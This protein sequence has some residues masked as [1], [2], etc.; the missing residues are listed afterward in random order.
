MVASLAR[1]SLK[2]KEQCLPR[3]TATVDNYEGDSVAQKVMLFSDK[4]NSLSV[5]NDNCRVTAMM[6]FFFF[7]FF[8]EG[9]GYC[10]HNV[11]VSVRLSILRLQTFV[12]FLIS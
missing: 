8:F 12:F 4:Q 1:N 11:R 10:F 6:F 2:I 9:V 3:A 5:K 7:F